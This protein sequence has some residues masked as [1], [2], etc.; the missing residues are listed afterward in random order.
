[1]TMPWNE[2]ASGST[3]PHEAG[4]SD[5]LKL[6]PLWSIILAVLVFVGSQWYFDSAPPSHRRPGTL[7]MHLIM[8]YMT[9]AALSS[10]ILLIGYVSR[11]TTAWRSRASW[12]KSTVWMAWSTSF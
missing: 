4:E 7:P 2:Q 6:L 5:S 1:M 12:R 11:S 8:G 3:Q 9:S 10:Y